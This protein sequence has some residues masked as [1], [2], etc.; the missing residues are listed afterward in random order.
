MEL[1]TIPNSNETAEEAFPLRKNV[2][3]IFVQFVKS[4][5]FS[6]R[7]ANVLL[8]NCFSLE[9][10]I[11]L[12]ERE[13]FSFPNCGR[14]TALE[15]LRFLAENCSGDE[16]KPPPSLEEQLTALPQKSSI[17]L[18]PLFSSKHLPGFT[19]EQL[20]PG[21]HGNLKNKDLAL[22]VRATG[23]LEKMH[24]DTIGEVMLTPAS[25]LLKQKNF[26]T[27]CLWELQDAVREVCN[28][29]VQQEKLV[30]PP[31]E[32]SLPSLPLYSNQRFRGMTVADL[33]QN[34]R[35]LT[36]LSDL[37]ISSRTS[38]VLTDLG[39]A[40]IGEVMLFPG[41]ELLRA[42]NFGHKSLKELREIVRD[43]CLSERKENGEL[44]DL[45]S[46]QAMVKHFVSRCIKRHRDQMLF[47]QR[48]CFV[49]GSQPT[50]EELGQEFGITRERVR[51]ILKKGLNKLRIKANSDKLRSF[52]QQLDN[53]VV[54]GGGLIRLGRLS[55]VLQA[56]YKWPSPPFPPA[57]GQLLLLKEPGAVLKQAN[58]IWEVPCSCLSCKLPGEQLQK[59]DFET[60]ESFHIQV[61]ASRLCDD[62]R[63]RCH[64]GKP[65]TTFYRAFIERLIENDDCHLMLHSDLLL[66]Y[67][68]W[69]ERYCGKLEEVTCQVLASHGKP[70]HFRDI[71]NAVR[72]VNV[73]FDNLTDNN[74]H[75]AV[76]RY[77][78]IEIINRGVYGLKKWGLGGY[79]S[80]SSAI[81]QL[82]DERGLPQR[83]RD[84]VTALGQEFSEQNINASITVATRFTNIGESF[85][86][87]PQNWR[88]R[89]CK[90]L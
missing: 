44:I 29:G 76:M 33:H 74:I 73:N 47:V 17:D 62:C 59:L 71:A 35:A 26:G 21:F 55:T 9:E 64:T 82:I 72:Q 58:D 32:H 38:K 3:D 18:L 2:R 80:V 42:K 79:R 13:L 7:A 36:R 5:T 43:L 22:S 54:Q 84:I 75:A 87:R 57:L 52:W 65:I 69:R 88:Q 12:T 4:E 41:N 56:H 48:F 89:T 8:K 78:S 10:F 86:D 60:T 34:F 85:Y 19:S 39:M 20:H 45:S 50:L 90:N 25:A 23:I 1:E 14:K 66:P 81:E 37:I 63:N 70:M 53:L 28:N 77:D 49:E 40:T 51:Q 30:L 27:K 31:T 61:V 11:S 68:R 6:A 46:Y 24:L 83:K 15:I 67:E 16:F